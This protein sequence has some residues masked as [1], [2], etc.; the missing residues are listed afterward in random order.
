MLSEKVFKF[1]KKIVLRLL[2][3][4]SIERAIK[5][6]LLSTASSVKDRMIIKKVAQTSQ[7]I[8]IGVGVLSS[9]YFTINAYYENQ[10]LYELLLFFCNTV[11]P[12]FFMYLATPRFLLSFF[13][14]LN[15]QN[16]P[17]LFYPIFT[18]FFIM[19]LQV[20]FFY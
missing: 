2:K 12:I 9:F 11:V 20:L 13:E 6:S 1:C 8:W 19:S 7:K 10:N 14:L 3:I 4:T 15:L 16:N 18:S 17:K 5:C